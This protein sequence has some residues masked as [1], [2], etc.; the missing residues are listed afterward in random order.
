MHLDPAGEPDREHGLEH[1]LRPEAPLDEVDAGFL[2]VLLQLL[3][4]LGQ[5]VD[6]LKG[7]RRGPV[8]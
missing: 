2:P 8:I 6:H 7:L 3:A 4:D 1:G 5:V